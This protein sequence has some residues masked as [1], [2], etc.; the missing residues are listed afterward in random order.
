MF[1]AATL[2]GTCT[3]KSSQDTKLT[4]DCARPWKAEKK[5]KTAHRRSLSLDKRSPHTCSAGSSCA[6]V[7]NPSI[8]EY[9]VVHDYIDF[10][11]QGVGSSESERVLMEDTLRLNKFENVA[12]SVSFS[13]KSDR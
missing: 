8:C 13:Y 3:Q 9:S 12:S 4:A 5:A 2:V 10:V 6:S 11:S 7:S 1:G